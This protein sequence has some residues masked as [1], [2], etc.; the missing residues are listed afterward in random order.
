MVGRH[1]LSVYMLIKVGV[2][3]MLIF[4]SWVWIATVD[5]V[6]TLLHPTPTPT[7]V[8]AALFMPCCLDSAV[9]HWVWLC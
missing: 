5:G 4:L 7:P 2:L 6:V 9:G 8:V 1:V 3:I